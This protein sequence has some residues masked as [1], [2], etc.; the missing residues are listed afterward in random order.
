MEAGKD[1]RAAAMSE[2][3]LYG[4][5][6]GDEPHVPEMYCGL[7]NQ[8]PIVDLWEGSKITGKAIARLRAVPILKMTPQGPQPVTVMMCGV[9]LKRVMANLDARSQ[10]SIEGDPPPDPGGDTGGGVP[11]SRK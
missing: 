7:C 2:K 11:S 1:H 4:H 3:I 6:P 5:P 9:C 10:R 8:V